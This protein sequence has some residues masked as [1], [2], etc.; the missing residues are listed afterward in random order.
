M[1][2]TVSER[3]GVLRVSVRG[4]ECKDDCGCVSA[5]Y[6][7]E[8]EGEV[9]PEGVRFSVEDILHDVDTAGVPFRQ[10]M[11]MVMVMVVVV[12]VMVVMVMVMVMVMVVVMM[13]VMVIVMVVVAVMVVVTVVVMMMVTVM[14][15]VMVI[16]V[17][18]VPESCRGT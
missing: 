10:L 18:S 3:M 9:I 17:V 13:M 4:R 14:V 11:V 2:V 7:C 16:V 5:R 8:C 15:M 6:V 12:V 1:N